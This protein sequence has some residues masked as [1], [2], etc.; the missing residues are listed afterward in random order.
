MGAVAFG[1]I[2]IRVPSGGC[3]EYS[4]FESMQLRGISHHVISLFQLWTEPEIFAIAR[5]LDV[6][7][8]Q[9]H[10]AIE[11]QPISADKSDTNKDNPGVPSHTS[12][13]YT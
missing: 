2:E 1:K 3:S 12:H 10:T 4:N 13:T 6:T 7:I 11:R 5:A 9:G 8:A